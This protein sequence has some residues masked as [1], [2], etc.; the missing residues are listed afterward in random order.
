MTRARR[1][2]SGLLPVVA[3]A[4][5]LAVL[6]GAG[7]PLTVPGVITIVVV[8]AI[9]RVAGSVFA[10]RRRARVLTSPRP[11]RRVPTRAPHGSRSRDR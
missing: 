3:V 11:P 2:I 1:I 10:R 7:V 4:V 8:I 9:A 6:R 5:I